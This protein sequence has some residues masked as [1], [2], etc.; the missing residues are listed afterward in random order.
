MSAYNRFHCVNRSDKC[1]NFSYS[2]CS[3][4]GCLMMVPDKELTQL[5]HHEVEIS[6]NADTLPPG[7]LDSEL[8]F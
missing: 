4:S 2:W 1:D 6:Q 7:K 3:F 5:I 8:P